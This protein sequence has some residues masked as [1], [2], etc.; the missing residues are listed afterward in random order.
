MRTTK[1]LERDKGYKSGEEFHI[2][3]TFIALGLHTCLEI[4]TNS[5]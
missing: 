3:K 5:E 4:N 1:L 2:S